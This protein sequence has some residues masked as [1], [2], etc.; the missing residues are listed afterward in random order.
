MRQGRKETFDTDIRAIVQDE[1]VEL[2][3]D[4][5][6]LG[7]N[8]ESFLAGNPCKLTLINRLVFNCHM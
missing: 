4:S 2:V 1:S 5:S 8:L 7:F 3:K 6:E